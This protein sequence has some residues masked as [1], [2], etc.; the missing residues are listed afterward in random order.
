MSIT[1][2]FDLSYWNCK[3][4]PL[5]LSFSTLIFIYKNVQSRSLHYVHLYKMTKI[6]GDKTAKSLKLLSLFKKH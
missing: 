1:M 2:I 3:F 5:V 6:R 4:F